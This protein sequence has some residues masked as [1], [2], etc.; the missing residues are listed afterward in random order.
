M[1]Y[2]IDNNNVDE[3][4]TNEDADNDYRDNCLVIPESM[5]TTMTVMP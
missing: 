1:F 4:E 2:P 5:T 3:N